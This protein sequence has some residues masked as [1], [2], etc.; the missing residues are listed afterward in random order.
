M[1]NCSGKDCELE[2]GLAMLFEKC[3]NKHMVKTCYL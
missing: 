3:N 2:F 1:I